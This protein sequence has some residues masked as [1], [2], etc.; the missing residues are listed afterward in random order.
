MATKNLARTAI[1]GGR[2]GYYKMEVA[3]RAT[4]ERAATRAFLDRVA[5]DPEDADRLADP[6]RLPVRACFADKLSPVHRYLDANCGRPWSKVREELFARF[7][8]RTTPG[9]HILFDHVLPDVEEDRRWSP[10]YA[11]DAHGMLRKVARRRYPKNVWFDE[12]PALRWLGDRRITRAG[13]RLMWWVPSKRIQRRQDGQI[14]T[15]WRAVGLL[16]PKDEAYVRGLPEK[17]REKVIAAA[18]L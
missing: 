3:A 8:I 4:G 9:R 1:E 11:V 5:R 14:V 16:D 15:R 6:R 12:R 17:T 18:R 7:D 10:R 2:C 13:D